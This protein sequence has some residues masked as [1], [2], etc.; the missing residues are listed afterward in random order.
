MRSCVL[1]KHN[2]TITSTF[3]HGDQ[4]SA[5]FRL[6]ESQRMLM[7]NK[8]S[9]MYQCV[10]QNNIAMIARTFPHDY[11]YV[12][13]SDAIAQPL[14]MINSN[15]LMCYFDCFTTLSYVECTCNHCNVILQYTYHDKQFCAIL[16]IISNLSAYSN[17][18]LHYIYNC[19]RKYLYSL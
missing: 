2:A 17:L 16:F 7:I 9:Q 13:Q 11:Q 1:Q 10:R 5:A 18:M 15:A 6:Q 12:Q 4:W 8:T 19:V 14:L 3:L